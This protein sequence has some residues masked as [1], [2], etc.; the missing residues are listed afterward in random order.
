MPGGPLRF[1]SRHAAAVAVA[2]SAFVADARAHINLSSPAPREHGP[3]RDPNSNVKQGPCG[4]EVNGRTDKVTVFEPG[5]TVAVTWVETTNHRSY[6]RIA[7][8]IDGDESFPTFA[9][10]GRGA[11]G[12][13]PSG[14]CP[15]DG[16]VILAYDMEDRNGGS[17]TLSVRLPDVEC[18]NC[19]LQVVQFMFDTPR[20]YYF[21]CADVA[22]RRASDAGVS[23]AGVASAA[24]KDAGAGEPSAAP[25]CWSQIA[26]D[27]GR[28]PPSDDDEDEPDPPRPTPP[29]A[30]APARPS[31]P[32]ASGTTARSD[33]GG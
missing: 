17:H 27:A 30:A 7:F 29:P 14:P 32:A 11:E 1:S 3:S 21:Q 33:D 8:D 9:G 12:I 4:Q 23:D 18:E 2:V 20:P 24:A 22:L 16:Q 13:D 28:R 19:T 25:G 26:P 10:T 5:A 15:V 6:Y 31:P